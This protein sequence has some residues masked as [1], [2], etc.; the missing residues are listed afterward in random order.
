MALMASKRQ[1]AVGAALDD[2]AV[3]IDGGDALKDLALLVRAIDRR[4]LW[5][6]L[7][8]EP[9]QV[10][11]TIVGVQTLGFPPV[12]MVVEPPSP[13][14]DTVEGLPPSP[15]SAEP[16]TWALPVPPVP[17]SPQAGTSAKSARVTVTKS[18]REWNICTSTL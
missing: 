9:E 14:V 17:L 8:W 4:N 6:E 11:S 2:T 7:A 15:P 16:P 12:E 10:T 13:P 1:Q 18:A 3:V 5:P